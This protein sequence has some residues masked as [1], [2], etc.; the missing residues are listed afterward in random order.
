MRK[1]SLPSLDKLRP[2]DNYIPPTGTKELINEFTETYPSKF[3][4]QK[5]VVIDVINFQ[6]SKRMAK[7]NSNNKERLRQLKSLNDHS[8][9]SIKIL[10]DLDIDLV[11]L[12]I[13]NGFK[14]PKYANTKTTPIEPIA[15]DVGPNIPEI[16]LAVFLTALSTSIE[17]TL[18]GSDLPRK[19]GRANGVPTKSD[20]IKAL[21]K[22]LN[23]G[24]K[25]INSL[26]VNKLRERKI[27]VIEAIIEDLD[28]ELFQKDQKL[29]S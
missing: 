22:T 1:P 11:R 10:G 6:I 21:D 27:S 23:L 15:E 24:I 14:N 12:L 13:V 19:V 4:L 20:L 16:D 3:D 8:L 29:I 9:K 5:L 28:F 18:S 2:M 25:R 26:G 7:E 17:N